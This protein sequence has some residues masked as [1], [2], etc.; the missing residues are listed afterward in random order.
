MTILLSK[1]LRVIPR[2]SEMAPQLGTA[3]KSFIVDMDGS[4]VET[5]MRKVLLLTSVIICCC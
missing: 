5:S 1:L 2:K 3:R 4:V